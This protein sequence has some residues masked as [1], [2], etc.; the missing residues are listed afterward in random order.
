MLALHSHF[1]T[2]ASLF[3][4]S[5]RHFCGDVSA[6]KSLPK[7]AAALTDP[8]PRTMAALLLAAGFGST[9]A[10]ASLAWE[11]R[12]LDAWAD[13][14]DCSPAMGMCPACGLGVAVVEIG[15]DGQPIHRTHSVAAGGGPAP[16]SANATFE[17]ASITKLFTAILMLEDDGAASQPWR[18]SRG[19]PLL[20]LHR[21]HALQQ[22]PLAQRTPVPR[23]VQLLKLTVCSATR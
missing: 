20:Q 16:F 22:P 4:T 7:S 1:P 12:V 15:A 14:P 8:H 13:E 23:A 5:Y 3:S 2:S 6:T 9:S 11:E 10:S 17:I 18:H 19:Q 21:G